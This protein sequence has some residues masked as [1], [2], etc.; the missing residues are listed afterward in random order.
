M[1]IVCWG[2]P[3][4]VAV[5]TGVNF[6][7]GF[8]RCTDVVWWCWI[9]PKLSDSGRL[10]VIT[11]WQLF[12]GKFWEIGSYILVSVLYGAVKI[13]LHTHVSLRITV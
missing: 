12:A 7:F 5:V 1:H 10:Y 9:T 8:N 6:R 4:L 2:I 13:K 3:I 11:L